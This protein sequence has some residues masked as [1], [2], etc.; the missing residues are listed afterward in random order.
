[1]SSS[2]FLDFNF[3]VS[4]FCYSP[5]W[6]INLT[7]YPSYGQ[8]PDFTPC[9][10]KTVLVYTPAA[11]LLL[12]SPIEF[13]RNNDPKN[14]NPSIPWGWMNILK[15]ITKLFLCLS[16]VLEEINLALIAYYDTGAI[17]GAD[18]VAP[19]IK[20]AAYLISIAMMFQSKKAGYVTSPTQWVYWLVHA[21]CQG[22]TFGSVINNPSLD[23]LTWTFSQEVL[24][25]FDFAGVFILLILY[26]MAEKSPKYTKLTGK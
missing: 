14:S 18:F 23:G 9:F 13:M 8:P 26:S 4:T 6:D 15:L 3:T 1:M 22:F 11:L 21:I 5:L 7:W 24:V 25:I 10:H 12:L 19:A 20:L 17:V 16:V 2:E